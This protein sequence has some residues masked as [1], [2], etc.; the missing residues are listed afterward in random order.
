MFGETVTERKLTGIR[1]V[2]PPDC[3]Y[4]TECTFLFE[5]ER[6][7]GEWWKSKDFEPKSDMGRRLKRIEDVMKAAI[8][9][10]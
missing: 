2:I 10:I 1:V 4:A 3:R 5:F 6:G 7:E 9:Q 8:R